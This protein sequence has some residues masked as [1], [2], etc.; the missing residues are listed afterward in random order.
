MN[1]RRHEIKI[2]QN[3]NR[4]GGIAISADVMR[5]NPANL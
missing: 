1:A 4:A 5:P 2:T 3:Q